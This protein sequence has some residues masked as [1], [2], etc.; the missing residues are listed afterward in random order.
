MEIHP[1]SMKFVEK[2]M[3]CLSAPQRTEAEL[4]KEKNARQE[5]GIRNEKLDNV[6]TRSNTPTCREVGGLGT[7]GATIWLRIIS[8]PL[9]TA[10]R[11][12]KGIS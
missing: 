7:E 11:L 9:Q 1:R 8:G 6:E 2:S 10:K 12:M 4:Y 3:R 5:V